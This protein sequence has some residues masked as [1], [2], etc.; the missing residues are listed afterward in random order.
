MSSFPG[1]PYTDQLLRPVSALSG[2]KEFIKSTTENCKR[3]GGLSPFR[4][5]G[6]TLNAPIHMLT[7]TYT[8]WENRQA[9][10]PLA[11]RVKRHAAGSPATEWAVCP[12]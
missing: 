9:V 11:S 2:R 4:G 7:R 6:G 3:S 10:R 8:A 1:C 12:L 5:H